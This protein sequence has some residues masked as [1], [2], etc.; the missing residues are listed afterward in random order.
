MSSMQ[1]QIKDGHN[2]KQI[3]KAI[4]K[5]L[6]LKGKPTVIIADTIK[7]KGISY[8]ENQAIW[9]GK[10]PNDEQLAQAMKDLDEQEAEVN[11]KY[12]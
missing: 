8:M 3:R 11:K 6:T 7:G 4:N 2:F 10:A 1:T 12:S 9:H 5:A